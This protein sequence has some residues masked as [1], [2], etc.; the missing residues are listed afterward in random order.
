MAGVFPG[1]IKRI[2]DGNIN[3]DLVVKVLEVEHNKGKIK[4][5]ATDGAERCTVALNSQ[6]CAEWAS[7]EDLRSGCLLRLKADGLSYNQLQGG[8][9]LIASE[10]ELAEKAPEAG[11]KEEDGAA[12]P[13]PAKVAKPDGAS[14][15]GAAKQAAAKGTSAGVKQENRA[16]SSMQTPVQPRIG[17][18]ALTP[19]MTPPSSAGLKERSL[20]V[21]RLNITNRPRVHMLTLCCRLTKRP[22]T[23]SSTRRAVQPIAALNPYN[24]NWTIKARLIKADR[25]EFNNKQGVPSCRAKLE[26]VDEEGTAIEITMWKEATDKWFGGLEQGKVYFFTRGKV[27]PANKQYAKVRNDYDITMDVSG[28]IE[29][30]EDQDGAKMQAKL[31]LVPIGQLGKFA[32]KKVPVDILGVVTE[33]GELASR[34]RKD[35]G[36]EVMKRELTLV[37]KSLKTVTV[38]VWAERAELSTAGIDAASRPVVLFT[39]GQV[40]EYNGGFSVSQRGDGIVEVEPELPEAQ[41]LRDW[42][43]A[44]GHAQPT[45]PIAEGLTNSGTSGSDC[46]ANN[47]LGPCC[48]QQLWAFVRCRRP[49]LTAPPTHCFIENECPAGMLEGHASGTTP[50]EQAF[51]KDLEP[52]EDLPANGDRKWINLSA[53]ITMIEDGKMHYDS[54]PDSQKKVVQQEDRWYCEGNGQSYEH[55]VRRYIVRAKLMDFTGEVERVIIYNEQ[56][57]KL[58][59]MTA[60]ELV[61][62]QEDLENEEAQQKFRAVLEKVQWQHKYITIGSSLREYNG[63]SYRNNSV[64]TLQDSD[65]AKECRHLIKNIRTPAS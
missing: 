6:I 24:M 11:V 25:F 58:F 13:G 35:N 48:R 64:Q 18:L 41:Q 17:T 45:Q 61:P 2:A 56:A 53:Y 31:Q 3:E 32:G 44:E 36:Q 21:M 9:L 5:R 60:D 43:A 40:R 39:A 20:T 38:T 10:V 37:D 19:G 63:K 14:T 15:P 49:D 22:L 7:N 54:A 51:V 4:L 8:H 57:E 55:R 34:K 42:W 47:P 33:V 12:T 30:C 28:D 1:C 65:Y 23:P 52:V 29:E 26:V 59:Q 16:P 50:R 62:L 46:L 27:K